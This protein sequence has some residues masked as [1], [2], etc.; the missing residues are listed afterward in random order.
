MLAADSPAAALRLAEAPNTRIDL[1]L[2]DL[3]M[4]G[5]DG[6]ELARR[7]RRLWPE[8]PVL[9]VSGYDPAP[10]EA[11]DDSFGFLQKPFSPAVLLQAI[12]AVFPR[13]RAAGQF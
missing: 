5:M 2:S 1:L 6:R 4:P 10:A 9:L 8:L 3:Q 7:L 11:P 13:G 12:Q